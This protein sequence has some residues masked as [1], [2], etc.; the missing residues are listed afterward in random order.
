M[1]PLSEL[2]KERMDEMEMTP[3][4]LAEFCEVNRATVYRWLNGEIDNMKR[5][6]IAALART[7]HLDP[8]LIVGDLNDD[9]NVSITLPNPERVRTIPVYSFL[10]C[11][12]GLFVDDDIV[13]TVSIPVSMLPN[14]NAEYFAQY[15]EGDSMEGAGIF[16]GDL[17]VFK[18]TQ[19]I[20]NG[21][22]GCFCIDENVAT[23]KKFSR[24]GG[25]IFLLPAN[26]KYQPIPIEPENQ[27]FRVV[28]LKVLLISK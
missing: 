9:K 26:D 4:Q 5:S 11:G 19:Q 20:N 17:I 14:P 16:S 21:E 23:C 27:C 8:A 28:G 3:D 15:A 6:N 1:K 22:I 18:K 25:S 12:T 13:D 2:L 24:I 10:S 7:L